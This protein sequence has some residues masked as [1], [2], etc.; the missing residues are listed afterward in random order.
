MTRKF[1]RSSAKS[2]QHKKRPQATAGMIR[3]IAGKWRGRRLPVHDIEGLRP[4]TDRVKETVFNWLMNEVDQTRCLDCFAGSGSLGFEVLSRGA[5]S[6][7][8][9]EKDHQAAKQL[10]ENVS[11]LSANSNDETQAEVIKADCLSYLATQTTPYDLVFIDP[12]FRQNLAEPVCELLQSRGLLTPA[13]LIYV[14][15]E[16]ELKDLAV[17]ASWQLLKEKTAGQVSFRLY[18]NS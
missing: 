2:S 16:S 13:A 12:P 10:T 18:Q 11:L 17:P 9:V 5:A 14:E 6:V 15:I 8:M 7:T 1:N 3:I 4:T